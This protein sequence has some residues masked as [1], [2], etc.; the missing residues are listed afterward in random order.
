MA[1]EERENDN[2][3][4]RQRVMPQRVHLLNNTSFLARYERVSRGNLPSNVIIRRTRTVGLRNRRM[5][6]TPKKVQF[7]LSIPPAPT[8]AQNRARRIVKKYR[9]IG[10][11][12][13]NDGSILSSITRLGMNFGVKKLFKRGLDIGSKARSSKI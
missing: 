3:L 13:Q 8:P 5:R 4:L 10:R 9:Q 2:T 11:K 12:K 7:D 1:E 6:Q